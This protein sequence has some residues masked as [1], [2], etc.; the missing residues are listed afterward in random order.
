VSGSDDHNIHVYTSSNGR[1]MRKLEGHEGGVWALQYWG[2]VLVSGST[3]R[4]VRVWD[5][6]W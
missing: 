2:R 6:N 4:S 5:V 1:L 3:D